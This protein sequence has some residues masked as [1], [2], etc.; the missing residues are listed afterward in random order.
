MI[1]SAWVTKYLDICYKPGGS[2]A[3]GLDCWGLVCLIYR[4]ERGIDLP[5]HDGRDVTHQSSFRRVRPPLTE[6][7]ILLLDAWPEQSHVGIILNPSSWMLHSTPAN[8]V[9]AVRIDRVLKK[10]DYFRWQK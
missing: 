3:S 4:Q 6:F 1:K 2:S 9:H 8:G 7:D 10:P 5:M